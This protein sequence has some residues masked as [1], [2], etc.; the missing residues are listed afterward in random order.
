MNTSW[1]RIYYLLSAMSLWPLCSAVLLTAQTTTMP[2]TQRYGSGLINI[3]VASVLP[4][5]MIT[6]TYSG[7]FMDLGRTIE[8]DMSG[9]EAG[10]G[11]PIKNFLSDASFTLGLFDRLEIGAT[12]QSFN[13]PD[14]GGNMWGVFGRAQLLRP[15]SQGLG[16]AFGG[17]Y[18]TAPNFE[19]GIAYQPTRLGI[20]DKR[21]R[22]SYVGLEDVNTKLSLYG[23]ATVHIQ[24]FDQGALPE[25]DITFTGGYGSGMFKDGDE[26]EFYRS[27]DSEGWFFGSAVHVGIGNSSILTVMSEYDGFDVNLGAQFDVAGIRIGAQY[28]AVNYS[29]P[30]GGHHSEY[31]K[32]KL[33]VL[34]S[35]AI[36]VRGKL[37]L[38]RPSLMERFAPDTVVLPAPP[39]DT[40]RI[41]VATLPPG[42]EG[43]LVNLC[44]STGETVQ[45]RLTPE[46]DTLIGPDRIPMRTLQPVLDFSG[47]YAG[48]AQWF[49]SGDPI[50]FEGRMYEKMVGQGPVDCEQI[51]RVGQHLGVGLFTP[52]NADRP[53]EIFYV[54]VRPGV[55]QTYFY[56]QEK[57]MSN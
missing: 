49:V 56:R 28:L 55:W 38:S 44:L 21:F 4:H 53:F 7:F 19:D 31:W 50:S 14:S 40:V 10:F 46:G 27:I 57:L 36:G 34:G 16:L 43:S 35:V 42:G 5:M 2:S 24:G 8:I 15:Q 26:L 29:E 41:E 30:S 32:P 18:V 37:V 12:L 23:V 48:T 45:V 6:G 39:P 11:A 22:N 52:R 17:R 33:A 9:N 54:A 13:E 20:P 47:T 25:H 51:M 1:G 3:P